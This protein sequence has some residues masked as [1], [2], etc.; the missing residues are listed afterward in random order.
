MRKTHASLPE[1]IGDMVTSESVRKAFRVVCVLVHCALRMLILR[2]LILLCF[3]L[4]ALMAVVPL[5]VF[6]SASYTPDALAA[7]LLRTLHLLPYAYTPLCL[8]GLLLELVYAIRRLILMPD[9]F[10]D[11]A[12]NRRGR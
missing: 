3:I 11:N 10:S 12:G 1:L 4:I 5:A 8:A 7:G 6:V 9:Y 2:P